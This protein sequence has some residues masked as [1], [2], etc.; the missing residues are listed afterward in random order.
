MLRAQEEHD[1]GATSSLHLKTY[2]G[3]LQLWQVVGEGHQA[4]WENDT[5]H[6]SI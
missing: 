4:Q 5:K 3:Y 6:I 1:M 2:Q